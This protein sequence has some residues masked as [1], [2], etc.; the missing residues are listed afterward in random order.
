M[1]IVSNRESRLDI[2]RAFV[3]K[4]LTVLSEKDDVRMV[5]RV[6]RTGRCDDCGSLVSRDIMSADSV[7]FVCTNEEC[8]HKYEVTGLQ[9]IPE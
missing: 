6:I 9:E 5:G 1:S 8:S 4:L 7:T 2:V 3:R